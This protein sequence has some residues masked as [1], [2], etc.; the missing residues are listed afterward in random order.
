MPGTTAVLAALERILRE[1]V[2]VLD[3]GMG[4][5][6]Q[7][8][9]LGEPDFRGERFKDHPRD[10]KGNSDV[11]VLTRPDIVEGI[12]DAYFEAGADLVETNTFSGTVI[13]QADYAL[14]PFV[15]EI[16]V[17]AS[18]IARRAADAWTARTPD[19]PRF[20]AGSMGPTNKTLSI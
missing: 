2:L 17:A 18:R 6:L 8:H 13:G 7:R 20:V 14:E 5:M 19:R 1:R 9:K 16:N 15:Y 12:H 10:L 3:G 4:T 11:L